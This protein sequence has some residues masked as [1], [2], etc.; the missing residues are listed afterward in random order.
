M[1]IEYFLP[2]TNLIPFLCFTIY[3]YILYLIELS[4]RTSVS[5]FNESSHDS[6]G[7]L[8]FQVHFSPSGVPSPSID[9]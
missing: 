7:K 9:D 5:E 3:F 1:D 2:L 8:G 6:S 4:C